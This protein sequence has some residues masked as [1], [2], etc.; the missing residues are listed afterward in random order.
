MIGQ[1]RHQGAA[2]TVVFQLQ[3]G[4]ENIA[5]LF[6]QGLRE[7]LDYPATIQ[8]AFTGVFFGE[9]E[10]LDVALALVHHAPGFRPDIGL[11]ATPADGANNFAFR[12]D[13]HFAF[14]AHRQ[15]AFRRDNRRHRG[16]PALVQNID[17][18]LKNIVY[19]DAPLL[20]E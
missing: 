10:L 9:D 3:Y 20:S 14:F 13:E 5:A 19:H 4:A 15:R 6:R 16:L 17:R 12:G 18:G 8:P 11:Q 2:S 1:N 7:D